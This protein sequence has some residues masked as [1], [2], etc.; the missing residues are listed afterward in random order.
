MKEELQNF[1]FARYDQ[2]QATVYKEFESTQK[3]SNHS[4]QLTFAGKLTISQYKVILLSVAFLDQ[5]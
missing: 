5:F 2:E 1:K 3:H 4:A